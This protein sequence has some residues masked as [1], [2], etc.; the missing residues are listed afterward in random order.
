MPDPMQNMAA[1]SLVGI[2][3]IVDQITVESLKGSVRATPLGTCTDS[4]S[5]YNRLT[6]VKGEYGSF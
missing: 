3:T 1:S 5:N 4:K 2:E 6:Y